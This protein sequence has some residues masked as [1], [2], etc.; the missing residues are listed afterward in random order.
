ML[1][2]VCHGNRQRYSIGILPL[3]LLFRTELGFDEYNPLYYSKILR[4]LFPHRDIPPAKTYSF[5]I[6]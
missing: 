6:P 2:F 1:L 3:S 5:F 4:S